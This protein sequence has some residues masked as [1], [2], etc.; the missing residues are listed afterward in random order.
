MLYHLPS[1]PSYC[2]LLIF[3]VNSTFCCVRFLCVFCTIILI[4]NWTIFICARLVWDGAITIL[5]VSL[6]SMNF[7]DFSVWGNE[8]CAQR[9]LFFFLWVK[10]F[11]VGSEKC[12]L[13]KELC[14]MDCAAWFLY[15]SATSNGCPQS[16]Y[17]YFCSSIAVVFQGRG[18]QVMKDYLSVSAHTF[19]R[20]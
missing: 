7:N 6:C 19:F 18:Q 1:K 16:W 3:S 13:S 20:Q 5:P 17:V 14:K 2:G 11:W 12:S 4:T 15:K 8:T 9:V 10:S